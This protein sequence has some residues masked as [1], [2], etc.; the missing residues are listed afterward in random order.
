MTKRLNSSSST[1]NLSKFARFRTLNTVEEA[2]AWRKFNFWLRLSN[3]LNEWRSSFLTNTANEWTRV[4]GKGS[5][6]DD[7]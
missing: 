6:G 1:M 4:S 3:P 5:V 2:A 7:A